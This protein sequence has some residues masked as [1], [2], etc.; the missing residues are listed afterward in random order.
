MSNRVDATDRE[1]YLHAVA[2]QWAGFGILIGQ[3][4]VCHTEPAVGVAAGVLALLTIAVMGYIRYV[5]SG[6]AL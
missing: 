3:L 6:E 4:T 1:L 2:A 5:L